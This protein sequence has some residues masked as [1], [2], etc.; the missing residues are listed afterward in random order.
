M[1][2]MKFHKLNKLSDRINNIKL[3]LVGDVAQCYF[4]CIFSHLYSSNEFVSV[5]L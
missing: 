3:V 1:V 2:W 5:A 4:I